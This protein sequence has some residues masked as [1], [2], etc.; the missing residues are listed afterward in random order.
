MLTLRKQGSTSERGHSLMNY[1]LR[2]VQACNGFTTTS[3]IQKLVSQSTSATS[4]STIA[5]KTATFP[6]LWKTSHT[7]LFTHK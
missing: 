3:K 2:I 6:F 1:S 5:C 7:A 4:F